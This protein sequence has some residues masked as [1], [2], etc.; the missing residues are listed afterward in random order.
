MAKVKREWQIGRILVS[1]SPRCMR[2]AITVTVAAVDGKVA[3]NA[4]TAWLSL[5][6]AR[7]LGR[8]LVRL[9]DKG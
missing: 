7:K 5:T 8:L 2:A 4:S 6:D 1:A 9:T 3:G